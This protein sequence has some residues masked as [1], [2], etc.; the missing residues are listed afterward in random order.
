MGSYYNGRGI[1]GGV[2]VGNGGAVIGSASP[3]VR[4]CCDRNKDNLASLEKRINFIETDM[5]S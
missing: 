5:G 4:T 1:V 3:V 2:G